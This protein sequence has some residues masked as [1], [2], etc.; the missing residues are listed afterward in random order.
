MKT[1]PNNFSS[2]DAHKATSPHTIVWSGD[3]PAAVELAA[4]LLENIKAGTF[5][6]SGRGHITDAANQHLDLISSN[7][8]NAKFWLGD[9]VVIRYRH[10]AGN[11]RNVS[12]DILLMTDRLIRDDLRPYVEL[13]RE[14]ERKAEQGM[15]CGG[16][17]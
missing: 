15:E 13:T 17:V 3:Y 6:V 4:W 2:I 11:P 7:L 1:D 12:K 16:A 5:G 8:V 10:A 9:K 14:R